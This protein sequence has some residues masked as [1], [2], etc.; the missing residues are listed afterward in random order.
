MSMTEPWAEALRS[1]LPNDTLPHAPPGEPPAPGRA[2]E[3]TAPS[4]QAPA[5]QTSAA[6]APAPQATDATPP[7]AGPTTSGRAILWNWVL[8]LGGTGGV[9]ALLAWLA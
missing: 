3:G 4:G 8:F 7:T 2:P 6:R 9:F 1:P 5:A